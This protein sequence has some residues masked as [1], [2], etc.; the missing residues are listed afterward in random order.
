MWLDPTWVQVGQKLI[1]TKPIKTKHNAYWKDLLTHST[2]SQMCE[3]SCAQHNQ[4]WRS[5]SANSSPSTPPCWVSRG[6]DEYLWETEQYDL[7]YM[8][9]ITNV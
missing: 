6:L 7:K 2:I 4:S 5:N 9:W 8:T 3:S 1:K